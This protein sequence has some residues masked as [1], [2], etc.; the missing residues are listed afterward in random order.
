MQIFVILGSP[1]ENLLIFTYIIFYYLM[2]QFLLLQFILMCM[3][4]TMHFSPIISRL[5]PFSL[6]LP[7]VYCPRPT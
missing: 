1:K 5:C 7:S 2:S 3:L 6:Y 4:I